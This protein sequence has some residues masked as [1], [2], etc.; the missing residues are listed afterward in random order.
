MGRTEAANET[1]HDPEH[2]MDS[3]VVQ[4]KDLDNFVFDVYVR[5]VEEKSGEASKELF[6]TALEATNPEKVGL[7]VVTD[8]DEETWELYGNE[9]QSS[10]DEWDSEEDDENGQ[11][12]AA[13][14]A[15]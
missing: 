7:L 8:E 3:S 14:V 13:F 6:N 1:R 4:K 10:G 12:H 2:A 11:F 9:D 15:H 5:Q